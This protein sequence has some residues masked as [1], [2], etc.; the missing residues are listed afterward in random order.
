[1]SA[2]TRVNEEQVQAELVA[3]QQQCPAFSMEFSTH[4][5]VCILNAIQFAVG[6]PALDEPYKERLRVIGKHIQAAF[7]K[8]CRETQRMFEI[9]WNAPGL[10]EGNEG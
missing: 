1:M 2:K 8:E 7:P 10:M 5:W 6:C 3:L 9:G 4:G